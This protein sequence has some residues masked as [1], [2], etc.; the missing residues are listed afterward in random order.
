MDLQLRRLIYTTRREVSVV[1]LSRPRLVG[2]KS[3][4]AGALDG[5]IAEID[6]NGIGPPIPVY[7]GEVRPPRSVMDY[8]G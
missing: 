1:G 6:D 8:S 3:C 7:I 2:E 5:H 4:C